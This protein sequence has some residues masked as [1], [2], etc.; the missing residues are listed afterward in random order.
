[1]L[2]ARA[3]GQ[4]LPIWA[5]GIATALVLTVAV[6]QYGVILTWQVRAQSAADAAAAAALSVQSS[7]WNQQLSALYAAAVEEYRLRT[8]LAGMVVA[9]NNDWSCEGSGTCAATYQKLRAEYLWSLQR[10]HDDVE[11]VQ[12]AS[13]YTAA[14][15]QS[16][17]RAIVQN[18]QQNCGTSGSGGDCAFAYTV[19]ALQPR[20]GTLNTVLQGA[21]AWAVSWQGQAATPKSD[22]VPLQIEVVTC[23][24]VPPLLPPILGFALPSFTAI[25]RAAATSAMVTQEWLDPGTIVNPLTGGPFQPVETGYE[26]GPIAPWY[27]AGHDWFQVAFGGNP[28]TANAS[29]DSFTENARANPPNEFTAVTGWWSTIPIAPFSGALDTATLTCAGS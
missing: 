5:L 27:P 2:T 7:A 24:K 3:R 20:A 10:Y 4:V 15:A 22:Y 19:S 17:A 28:A 16:D 8:V 21:D 1:M 13:Q 26:Q 6:L 23:A 9:L 18:L 25:G 11:L 14:Q 29:T 12:R